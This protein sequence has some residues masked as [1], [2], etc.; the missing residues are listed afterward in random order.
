M[1]KNLLPVDLISATLYEHTRTFN[2]SQVTKGWSLKALW[3]NI[4][5][6]IVLLKRD[7]LILLYE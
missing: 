4:K 5:L 3:V 6:K 7:M 2:G 1:Q